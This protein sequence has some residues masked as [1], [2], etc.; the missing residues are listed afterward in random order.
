MLK[1]FK[2]NT[3]SEGNIK[4]QSQRFLG[5]SGCDY[6]LT[7][8]GQLKQWGRADKYYNVNFEFKIFENKL[9]LMLCQN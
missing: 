4:L 9:D 2:V 8:E 5:R 7:K 1:L 6:M 3:D